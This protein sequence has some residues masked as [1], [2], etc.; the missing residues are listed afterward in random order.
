MTLAVVA[1]AIA[2]K[3]G[4]AGEAWVRMSWAEGLRQLGFDVLVVEELDPA[5]CHDDEGAPS[6][7][8]GSRERSWFDTVV[9]EFGFAGA[10]ALVCGDEASG[11]SR[12]GVLERLEEA[13][14]LVNVSG[15]LRDPELL[16]RARHR[17]FV[18]LDPGYTQL[19]HAAGDAAA[20]VA[21]H[22]RH[23]SVGELVGSGA[24][25]LPT[26]EITWRPVRQPVVLD[27]WP[28]AVAPPVRGFTTVA[29]W[30]APYG[31]PAAGGHA[32]AGKHH[33]FRRLLDL[34]GQV[35]APLELALAIDPADE[36]DRS[37][38]VAHGWRVV[39]PAT[40]AGTVPAFRDYVAGSLG[41]LSCAQ[42]VYVEAR[43]GWLSDRTARYLASGRPAVVQDTGFGSRVP[44]GEGLLA[45]C[46]PA[47]AAAAAGAVL[48]DYERHAKAARALAEEHFAAEVVLGRFLEDLGVAP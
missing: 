4:N 11:V 35:G 44:T 36:A 42:G 38:L 2:N 32:Y 21:G 15:H 16:R 20:H 33:E 1:G 41:E 23:F 40:V 10:A 43:T 18:D 3:A 17:V 46:D 47:G 30:R 12:P 9:A 29:T 48:E 28:C 27:R 45:F 26:G 25:A 39:D 34:P 31:A 5:R 6:A 22:H 24:C 14:L 13:A 7:F 37:A 8:D 19:W